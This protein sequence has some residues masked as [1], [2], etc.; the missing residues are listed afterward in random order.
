MSPQER[1]Q[2][3]ALPGAMPR[4]RGPGLRAVPGAGCRRHLLAVAR[5][6]TRQVAVRPALSDLAR[7]IA[8]AQAEGPGDRPCN[9]A[10]H[11]DEPDVDDAV[12]TAHRP[13]LPRDTCARA[14]TGQGAV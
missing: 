6:M 1:L 3:R 9:R 10:E 4:S 13:Q 5:A 14:R 11:Q 2:P 8:A 7:G 12:R